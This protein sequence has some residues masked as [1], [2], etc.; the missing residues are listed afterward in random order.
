MAISTQE[1]T[2]QKEKERKKER[3]Q[4][5]TSRGKKW[6]E[7]HKYRCTVT[8]RA[9]CGYGHRCAS[10]RKASNWRWRR[11]LKVQCIMPAAAQI[12]WLV[13]LLMRFLIRG[14][15][16]PDFGNITEL[17][18]MIRMEKVGCQWQDSR[19][20]AQSLFWSEPY[21]LPMNVPVDDGQCL[22]YVYLDAWASSLFPACCRW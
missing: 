5:L 20:P 15:Y 2:S 22:L 12:A 9:L 6:K 17:I 19:G 11:R 1:Q 3:K 7:T 14:L 18:K 10:R 13:R 8:R 4:H 16:S 21:C